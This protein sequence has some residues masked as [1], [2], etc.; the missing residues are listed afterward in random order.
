MSA[1]LAVNR[2]CRWGV[3]YMSGRGGAPRTRLGAVLARVSADDGLPKGGQ[4]QKALFLTGQPP[5]AN[6]REMAVDLPFART[7]AMLNEETA[8]PDREAAASVPAG[9]STFVRS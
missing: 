9:S 7:A 3:K 6:F 5:S 1:C 8:S 4:M 2:P